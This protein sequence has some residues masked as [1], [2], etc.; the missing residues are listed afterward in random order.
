[1]LVRDSIVL[2]RW[3]Y[4]VAGHKLI[5]NKYKSTIILFVHFDC[6]TEFANCCL[7]KTICAF[8]PRCQILHINDLSG[9][10]AHLLMTTGCIDKIQSGHFRERQEKVGTLFISDWKQ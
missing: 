5:S 10:Q 8:F 4:G 3:V 1:M 2:Q 7:R 6:C 9:W